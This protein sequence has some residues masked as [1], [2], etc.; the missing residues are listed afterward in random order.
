MGP[1]T[2]E[3][4]T[5][6]PAAPR[7]ENQPRN[8]PFSRDPAPAHR[9]VLYGWHPVKAALENPRRRIRKLLATENAVRRLKADGVVLPVEPE[10]VRPERLSTYLPADAVHQGLM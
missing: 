5:A 1:P 4:A 2:A 3:A 10:L 8:N 7:R 6:S 9:V